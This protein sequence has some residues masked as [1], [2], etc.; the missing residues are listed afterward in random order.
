MHRLFPIV[1]LLL[2][3]SLLL[4]TVSAQDGG[5]PP[6]GFEIA[7]GVTAEALAFVEGRDEPS[8]YRLT[9]AP[10]TTY[11]IEPVPSISLGVLESGSLSFTLDVPVTVTRAG[12]VDDPGEAIAADEEFTLEAGDYTVLPPMAGGEIR[13]D[14][15]EPAAVIV[16]DIVPAAAGTPAATPAATPTT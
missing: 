7:P 13:N 15:T 16:A 3:L 11:A 4:P 2:V 12:A 14:G 6:G 5:P 8:L 10:D 1:T 9:F